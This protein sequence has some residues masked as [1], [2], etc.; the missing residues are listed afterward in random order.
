MSLFNRNLAAQRNG[1]ILIPVQWVWLKVR[2]AVSWD[3]GM[4]HD[5]QVY[6]SPQNPVRKCRRG[7][8]NV[9]GGQNNVG[10]EKMSKARL[11]H[12]ST[13]HAIIGGDFVKYRL[14]THRQVCRS[15]RN[16]VSMCGLILPNVFDG[17][18]LAVCALCGSHQ[19]KRHWDIGTT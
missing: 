19:G 9:I 7:P 13:C 3:I 12:F 16:S 18:N 5:H 11:S 15:P 8:V 10:S 17:Q 2:L 6:R 4:R 1:W 14:K